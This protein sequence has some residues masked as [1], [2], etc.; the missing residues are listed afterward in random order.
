M[1]AVKRQSKGSQNNGQLQ[2]TLN[3][4]YGS[5]SPS[6]ERYPQPVVHRSTLPVLLS[7]QGVPEEYITQLFTWL[8]AQTCWSKEIGDLEALEEG[9]IRCSYDTK[10]I[11]KISVEKRE[12]HSYKPGQRDRIIKDIVR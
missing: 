10:G 2:Q 6:E 11:Q 12:E 4:R 1:S 7:S 9:V 5:S 3:F 8:R